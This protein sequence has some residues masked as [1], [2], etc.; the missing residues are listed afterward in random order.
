MRATAKTC[1]YNCWQRG[2][3]KR[4]HPANEQKTIVDKR[5]RLRPGQCQ[6]NVGLYSFSSPQLSVP[7]VKTDLDEDPRVE[8]LESLHFYSSAN[9]QVELLKALYQSQDDEGKNLISAVCWEGCSYPNCSFQAFAFL[10]R[11]TS[12]RHTVDLLTTKQPYENFLSW[13]NL[14]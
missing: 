5:V 3:S 1:T 8:P 6:A 7:Q 2:R 4:T 10:L 9:E 13:R 14:P 11:Y 12:F